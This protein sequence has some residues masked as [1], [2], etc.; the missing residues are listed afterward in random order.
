MR[1]VGAAVTRLRRRF[2]DPLSGAPTALI[3][4]VVG[5]PLGEPPGAGLPHHVTVLYPFV[6]A[7]R[8]RRSFL[9]DLE[10]TFGRMSPFDYELTAV[11]RF[12]GVLYLA[13]EPA[14]RFDE[15]TDACL[16]R[17]PEHPP[18]GGAYEQNVPHVT[19]A[20]GTEPPGLAA[21]LSELL[22]L[23]ARAEGV[24]LMRRGRT[25]GWRRVAVVPFTG[26]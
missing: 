13:P 4:P 19:L 14:E 1:A 11:R 2:A 17:W 25:R 23:T 21:R 10:A 5:L 3:V 16:S 8:V 6:P 24:W 22:P 18:Y 15:L 12:P 26:R 9:R 7:R 20:Q